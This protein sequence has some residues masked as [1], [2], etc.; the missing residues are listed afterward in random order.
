[1]GL[2]HQNPESLDTDLPQDAEDLRVRLTILTEEEY[3]KLGF[4]YTKVLDR[5]VLCNNH[6]LFPYILIFFELSRTRK[7]YFHVL[8]RKF[9]VNITL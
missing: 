3:L 8:Q 7:K 6:F 9:A 4:D 1:M 2:T 5:T